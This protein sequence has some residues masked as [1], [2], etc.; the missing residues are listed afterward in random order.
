[1]EI[2]AEAFNVFNRTNFGAPNSNRSNANFGT[3]T[4]A[5]PARE[6]QF[7]AKFLF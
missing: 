4:T 1:L 3:I 5:F 2:R 6:L 7:A